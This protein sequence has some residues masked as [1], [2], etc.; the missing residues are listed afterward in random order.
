VDDSVDVLLSVMLC[1]DDTGHIIGY[2]IGLSCVLLIY[3]LF[4]RCYIVDVVV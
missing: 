2:D 4:V 3:I 1:L